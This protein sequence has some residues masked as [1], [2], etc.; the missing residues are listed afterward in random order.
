MLNCKW[1]YTEKSRWDSFQFDF[2]SN[3]LDPVEHLPLHPVLQLPSPDHG[4]Q[5]LLHLAL[6]ILLLLKVR[7]DGVLRD[8][9]SD[10]EALLQLL[11]NPDT[12]KLYF[13]FWNRSMNNSLALLPVNKF[14]IFFS[15]EALGTFK[16]P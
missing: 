8:L 12:Q 5:H 2:S 1:V 13:D 4:G 15:G 16:V 11:L 6:G 10:W 9:G 7:D 14:L 3:L